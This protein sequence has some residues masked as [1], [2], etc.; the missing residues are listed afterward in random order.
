MASDLRLRRTV[1]S[2]GEAYNVVC[3]RRIVG[4][5][6]LSNGS[7]AARWAW[8]LAYKYQEGRMPTHGYEES[9]GAAFQALA[10]SWQKE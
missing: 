10:R 2:R 5:I 6:Q 3:G 9:R 1:A 8:T 4:R 7:P